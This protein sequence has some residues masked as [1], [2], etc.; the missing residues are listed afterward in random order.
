[1][2]QEMLLMHSVTLHESD[3]GR[4]SCIDAGA[5]LALVTLSGEKSVKENGNA[6][7]NVARALGNIALSD[8]GRQSCIDAGATLA[9]VTLSGE[10][11]VKEN[12]DAAGNVARALRNIAKSDTGRQSCID[13]GAP[14][15]LVH[16][17][18]EFMRRGYQYHFINDDWCH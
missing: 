8:T 13:A 14:I 10:K 15:A 5:P 17:A 2:Q 6:A 16:L 4:Q 3:T 18:S 9:L 1:M 7:S 11:S 12:G